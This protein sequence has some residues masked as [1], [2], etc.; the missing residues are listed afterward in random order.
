[1]GGQLAYASTRQDNGGLQDVTT[2]A[3]FAEAGAEYF[4]S[5][6]FSFEGSVQV[7]YS[8]NEFKPVAGGNSTKQTSFGTSRGNLGANFYF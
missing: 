1:V 2:F 8:S 6:N 5:K 3:I 7:G 4:L